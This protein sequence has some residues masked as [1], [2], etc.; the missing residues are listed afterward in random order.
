MKI[1]WNSD[2]AQEVLERLRRADRGLEDGLRQA[3]A[4]RAA[5]ADANAEGD[6]RALTALA[7]RFAGCARGLEALAQELAEF[8]GAVL[9]ADAEFEEAER[10]ISR[11]AGNLESR[12]APPLEGEGAAV[13]WANWEPEAFAVMPEMRVRAMRVPQWLEQIVSAPS[14]L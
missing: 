6:D 14:A 13:R 4:V 2:A 5:L 7:E 9:R 8:R 11:T 12:L 1:Q 3:K 10:T